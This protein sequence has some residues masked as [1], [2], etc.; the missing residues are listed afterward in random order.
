MYTTTEFLGIDTGQEKG[1]EIYSSRL[2][3]DQSRGTYGVS[4]QFGHISSFVGGE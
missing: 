3:Y 1:R 4:E 2:S